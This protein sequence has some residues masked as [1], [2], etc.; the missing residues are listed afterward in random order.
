MSTIKSHGAFL[1]TLQHASP[2]ALLSQLIADNPAADDDRLLSLFT[3]EVIDKQDYLET[4][5]EYWFINNMRAFRSRDYLNSPQRSE[6]FHTHKQRIMSQISLLNLTM[7][8]GKRL[9]GCSGAECAAVGGWLARVAERVPEGR[10]VGSVFSERQIQRL[11]R[12]HVNAQTAA[13]AS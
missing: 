1:Q 13:A 3:S 7:P 8:N 9:A 11:Y 12:T 10:L 6:E 2:R 5:I 4:I